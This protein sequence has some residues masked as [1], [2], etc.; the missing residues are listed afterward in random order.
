[1]TLRRRLLVLALVAAAPIFAACH[2]PTAAND[3]NGGGTPSDSTG[4]KDLRPWG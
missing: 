4:F 3:P 1:M 2:M